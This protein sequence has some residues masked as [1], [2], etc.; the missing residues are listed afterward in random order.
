MCCSFFLNMNVI[1]L[2]SRVLYLARSVLPEHLCLFPLRLI[3]VLTSRLPVYLKIC[4]SLLGLLSDKLRA[5]TIYTLKMIISY[6]FPVQECVCDLEDHHFSKSYNSINMH[7]WLN[8]WTHSNE[9]LKCQIK[10]VQYYRTFLGHGRKDLHMK[11]F[12]YI[13]Y[14]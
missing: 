8:S 4:L 11:P 2:R 5:P 9:S 7:Y 6:P 14:T 1:D 12:F 3:S 13:L 10:N